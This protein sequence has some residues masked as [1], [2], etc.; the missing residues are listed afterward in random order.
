MSLSHDGRSEDTLTLPLSLV[1]CRMTT[2]F[3]LLVPHLLCA[4]PLPHPGFL[5]WPHHVA[6]GMLVP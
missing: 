2:L 3:V 4:P 5:F 1:L 6:C